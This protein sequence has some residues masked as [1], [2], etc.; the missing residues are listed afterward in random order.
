MRS[1]FSL[2]L[3]MVALALPLAGCSS[4]PAVC[5][6]GVVAGDEECDDGAESATCNADC[7]LPVCG[8][9]IVNQLAGEECEP[10]ETA[11]WARCSQQC[12]IGSSLDGTFGA[13]WEPLTAT[14]LGD[15]VAGLQSFHY[16]GMPYIYDF[17]LNQRYVIATDTWEDLAASIP[18][19]NATYW[20]NAAV[21]ADY[22]WV[23]RDEAMHRFDLVTETWETLVGIIPDGS[24]QEGAT[25]YDGDGFLWY[26]GLSD[27]LVRYDPSDGSVM[28]Y[29]HDAAFT[30]F[31]AYET[32]MAYDPVTN[33]IAFAGF[34]NDRFLIF[35]IDDE[36]FHEGTPNPDGEIHDNSCQDRAGGIYTGNGDF[37]LMYRYDIADDSWTVLPTLPTPHDNN[38]SC[39]VSEDGYLYY[40]TDDS[41][42]QEFFRL[43]LGT[44]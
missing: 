8:D 11:L 5:G 12:L 31:D 42:A 19:V 1:L 4:K 6:D 26:H 23:A 13:A 14:T 2:L 39:V 34:S 16:A 32:R 41:G 40:A 33:A 24:D 28:V 10:T 20:P 25:I 3:L 44:R 43:P 9:G 29:A 36:T 15:N 37:T 22:L 30:G 35:D 7:T 27:D 17:T 18:W 21:D 38:A